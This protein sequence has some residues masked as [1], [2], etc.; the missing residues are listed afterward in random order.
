MSD[1]SK[2][3]VARLRLVFLKSQ[4]EWPLAE[5]R[6]IIFQF[7]IDHDLMQDKERIDNESEASRMFSNLLKAITYFRHHP[8]T[9]LKITH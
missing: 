8:L 3:S 4:F 7:S 5:G 2:F 1:L 6:H 9:H